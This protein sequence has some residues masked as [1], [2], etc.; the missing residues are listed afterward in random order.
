MMSNGSSGSRIRKASKSRAKARVAIFGPSGSG[1]TFSSLAIGEGM[2]GAGGRLGVID[3][4]RG[5]ASK[6]SDRFSFD[7]I[8]LEPAEKT[9]SGYL[10]AIREFASAGHEVLVIDSLTHAWQELLEQVER[11]AKGK[12]KGNTWSAWSE[13]TPIQRALIDA[14][15]GYPGHV[16]A[17]MRSKTAWETG[18]GRGGKTQPVRIGL[19]PEQGKGIEYEFDLLLE[20]S[21]E[22]AATIIKDRS[23]KFQDQIIDRPGRD[24]G[25]E[26]ARWLDQGEEAPTRGAGPFYPPASEVMPAGPPSV[27]AGAP[28]R[29]AIPPTFRQMVEEKARAVN[30]AYWA[31]LEASGIE[32]PDGRPNV[33]V[34]QQVAHAY[35]GA[36]IKAGTVENP[37][38]GKR[39]AGWAWK[40]AQS[41]CADRPDQAAEWASKYIAKK[42]AEAYK[43]C[44]FF[45]EEARAAEG[46]G[47]GD[48]DRGMANEP[49]SAFEEALAD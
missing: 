29:K 48:P 26:L 46:D 16:L 43:A 17:T 4:E 24:F 31:D 20:L 44:G 15:L 18:E 21:V 25:G 7:E 28:S 32:A 40:T 47:L 33:V 36:A 19:A 9:V 39:T 13:G 49:A 27:P 8:V 34:P 2:A 35:T 23:G 10:G 42:Q 1:K 12:Y 3:T 6:Y 45:E 38:E 14:I 41:L 5:S 22:H 11:L 37:G 30:A